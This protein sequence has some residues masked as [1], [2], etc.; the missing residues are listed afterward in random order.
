MQ[1]APPV[2]LPV[3]Q[4][5]PASGGPVA[6]QARPT[7]F[8]AN[9]SA[10]Q[11]W[12][13]MVDSDRSGAISAPE[14]QRAL[15]QGGLNY[16]LKMISSI[17]RTQSPTGPAQLDFHCFCQVQEMLTRIQQVFSQHD[18]QRSNSLDLER[19][20]AALAQLGYTLDKQPG[21]AFYT[22]CQSFDFDLR[23]IISLDTFVAMAVS[24]ENAKKV[25]GRFGTETV[26]MNFDQ[27]VWAS[28]QI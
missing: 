21:G 27:F 11:Q 28:S 8:T 5:V 2:A 22:L 3:A 6:P 12:F 9:Q 20:Y 25:F 18:V 23:G 19:V 7:F 10:L 14:L 16:S 17:I 24:L 4:A 26:P 1:G 15:A 13:G